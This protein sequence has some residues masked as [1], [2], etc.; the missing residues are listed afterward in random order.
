MTSSTQWVAFRGTLATTH[1]IEAYGGIQLPRE[2]LDRLA[3]QINTDGL[4]MSQHHDGSRRLRTRN[5]RATVV[6]RDDEEFAL[7]GDGEVHPDDAHVVKELGF[8]SIT[9][10]TPL[11]DDGEVREDSEFTIAGNAAWFPDSALQ[12]AESTIA[13]RVPSA[14]ALRMYEFGFEADPNIVVTISKAAWTLLGGELVWDGIKLVWSARKLLPGRGGSKT[15]VLLN[16]VDGEKVIT[17]KVETNDSG[18]A[19]RAFESFDRAVDRMLD[20][21]DASSAMMWNEVEQRWEDV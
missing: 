1:A 6:S 11:R 2:V 21:P 20:A 4:P 12:A 18:V 14:Q 7:V 19:E 17:G 15:R 3:E 10:T 5:L 16:V 8:L 9:L 13:T